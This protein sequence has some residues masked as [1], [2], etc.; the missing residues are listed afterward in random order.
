MYIVSDVTVKCTILSVQ[1]FDS[2]NY[3]NLTVPI[4][5]TSLQIAKESVKRYVAVINEQNNCNFRQVRTT[6]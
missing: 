6:N 2:N 5:Q 3:I 1:Y 4:A